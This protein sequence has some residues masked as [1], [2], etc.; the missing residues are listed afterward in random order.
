MLGL[1]LFFDSLMNFSFSLRNIDASFPSLRQGNILTGILVHKSEFSCRHEL[2]EAFLSST[3]NHTN[4]RILEADKQRANREQSK[5]RS[6]LSNVDASCLSRSPLPA[7]F[8]HSYKNH[9][10]SETDTSST[11]SCKNKSEVRPL[12]DLVFDDVRDPQEK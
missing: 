5:L 1:C 9:P 2:R 7:P 12:I 10:P 8:P 3:C 11:Y 4:P 6:D